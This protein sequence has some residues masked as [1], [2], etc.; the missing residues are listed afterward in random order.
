MNRLQL[1]GTAKQRRPLSEPAVLEQK[2]DSDVRRFTK[3]FLMAL[4]AFALANVASFFVRSDRYDDPDSKER[5]GFPLLISAQIVETS[6]G[7]TFYPKGP[8]QYY[9]R[10][11]LRADIVIASVGSV[12]VAGIYTSCI[13]RVGR[14]AKRSRF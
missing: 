5:F 1:R 8:Y 14:I 9:S 2:L 10:A 12:L 7:V 13:H 4:L 6:G 3:V 11:A